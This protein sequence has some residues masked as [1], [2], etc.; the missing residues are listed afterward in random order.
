M[1]KAF[2]VSPVQS[3]TSVKYLDT[4][5]AEQTLSDTVYDVDA[6]QEPGLITLGYNQNWPSVRNERG[7]VRV[8][9]VAGYALDGT[10]Y[11]KN[12][13]QSIKQ[14]ILMIVEDLYEFTG[15]KV[16]GAG[17]VINDNKAVNH[18]LFKH[19]VWY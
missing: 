9:F 7:S 5:G 15:A 10:D 2:T 4:D 12:I 1:N 16:A 8:V 14:A 13:P 3:V 17:N 18:L 11:R 6:V 19:R